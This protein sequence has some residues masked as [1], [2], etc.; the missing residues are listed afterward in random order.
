M[1]SDVTTPG[2][3][4]TDDNEPAPMYNV[5]LFVVNSSQNT[6]KP[7]LRSCM[8][9]RHDFSVQVVS[10]NALDKV[11]ADTGAKVSVCGTVQAKK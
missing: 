7:K 3:A 5:N 8:K 2:T 6:P 10:N 1:D 9:K 11:L 4:T